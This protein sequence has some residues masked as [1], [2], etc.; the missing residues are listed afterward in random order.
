MVTLHQN[1]LTCTSSS[2]S[3]SVGGMRLLSLLPEGR[4]GRVGGVIGCECETALRSLDREELVLFEQLGAFGR[5]V[6]VCCNGNT[7]NKS[8]PVCLLNLA[9]PSDQ[10]II[11]KLDIPLSII[12]NIPQRPSD[13]RTVHRALKPF[14]APC[15][16]QPNR[17]NCNLATQSQSPFLTFVSR[18]FSS[19]SLLK[20]S[21]SIW[22]FLGTTIALRGSG[23]V[24]PFTFDVSTC[25]QL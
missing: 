19:L 16:E 3:A 23:S 2:L 8:Q 18:Y 6:R 4:E 11:N 15:T 20:E 10:T 13:N 24:S 14:D 7:D 5:R 1:K 21:S 9:F 22:L 12:V 25:M 17:C